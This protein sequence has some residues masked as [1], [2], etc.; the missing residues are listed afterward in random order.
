MTGVLEVYLRPEYIGMRLSTAQTS[1][2]MGVSSDSSSHTIGLQLFWAG[3]RRCIA[4]FNVDRVGY[5]RLSIL[6][7]LLTLVF[8]ALGTTFR[9]QQ[10]R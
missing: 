9:L 4:N 10:L 7:H 5:Y 8:Y 2:G 6:L 1:E 3:G